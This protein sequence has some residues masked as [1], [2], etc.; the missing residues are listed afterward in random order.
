MQE[1][2]LFLDTSMMKDNNELFEETTNAALAK[3]EDR[4][5]VLENED[6]DE[7]EEKMGFMERN[8]DSL[9]ASLGTL[10]GRLDA[11]ERGEGLDCPA[12]GHQHE[13]PLVIGAADKTVA[14]KDRKASPA[15]SYSK[16]APIKCFQ[17]PKNPFIVKDK[18]VAEK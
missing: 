9:E 16:L 18:A 14:E 2:R 3:V 6:K 15:K 17:V 7:A 11:L 12:L 4:V 13:A 1:E 5:D 10:E 8:F